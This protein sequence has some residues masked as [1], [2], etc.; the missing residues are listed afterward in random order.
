MTAKVSCAACGQE[1]DEESR[2]HIRAYAQ[3]QAAARLRACRRAVPVVVGVLAA[4]ATFVA[5]VA[6]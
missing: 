4:I 3:E 2:A 5:E 6:R 1:L